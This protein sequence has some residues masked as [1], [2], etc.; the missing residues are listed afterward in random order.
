MTIVEKQTVKHYHAH[1]LKQSDF[2]LAKIQGWTSEMGQQARFNAILELAD[3][4]E[5]SVLDIGCG[6]GDFK[7]RLDQAYGNVRYIGL[8]QQSE[9]ITY[10]KQ[11]YKEQQNTWFYEVDFSTC[12]LPQVDLVVASG[13]LSY[14]ST[15]SNYYFRMIQRFYDAARKALIFNMLDSETFSSGPLII[16]HDKK[17]VYEQCQQLCPNTSLKTGYTADDFTIKMERN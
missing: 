2:N 16:A 3:F 10:A 17:A 12:Q 11:R 1:R 13:V 7:A 5:A 4:T 6:Y 9:F 15:A 14:Y 8:D